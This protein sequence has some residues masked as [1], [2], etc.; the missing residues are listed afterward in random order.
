MAVVLAA[1]GASTIRTWLRAAGR[2]EL[3][4]QE[5][6]DVAD[7]RPVEGGRAEI[8]DAAVGRHEPV[9]VAAGA[10]RHAVDR[11]VEPDG[12]GRARERCVAVAE[13]AAVGGD[14]P[15]A[16]ARGCR[17]H[18]DHR[19]VEAD[20]TGRAPERRVAVTEDAAVGGHQPVAP[21]DGVAAMPTTGWLRRMEPVEPENV[22][23][24]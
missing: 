2:S 1:L 6:V 3:A 9:P 21:P 4:H 10:R 23:S 18:A 19:L 11:L 5:R 24:P 22:A 16:V 13:D 12:A 8:E 20:G 7:G 14:E 15:V 17:R